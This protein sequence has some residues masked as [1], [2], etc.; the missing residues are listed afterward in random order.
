MYAIGGERRC[1]RSTD[2]N[3]G[4]DRTSTTLQVAGAAD[5]LKNS[6]QSAMASSFELHDRFGAS[7]PPPPPRWWSSTEKVTVGGRG[8]KEKRPTSIFLKPSMILDGHLILALL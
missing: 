6:T 4:R 5:L 1:D 3:C 2:Q 7:P 8:G